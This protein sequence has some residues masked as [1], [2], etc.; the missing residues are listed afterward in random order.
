MKTHH[1]YRFIYLHSTGNSL[2]SIYLHKK[3]FEKKKKLK[4]RKI[5]Y[6]LVNKIYFLEI[7]RFYSQKARI[8]NDCVLHHFQRFLKNFYKVV[9]TFFVSLLCYQLIKNTIH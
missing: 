2:F 6:T 7:F 3:K 5:F 9:K 1:N 4:K 8:E